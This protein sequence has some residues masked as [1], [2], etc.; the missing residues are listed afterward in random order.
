MATTRSPEDVAQQF[1]I[2][3]CGYTGERVAKQL[4]ALGP[5]VAITRRGRVFEFPSLIWDLDAT[6]PAGFSLSGIPAP[7]RVLYLVP[8]PA[9]GQDDPRISRFLEASPE[10]SAR[11][12]YIS[13]TSV[14]GDAGG[15]TVSEETPPAPITD[16][17]R[18]R[19]TAETTLR[20]W[21]ESKNVDWVILRVPGIYGPGR[22]PL[23]HLRRGEPVLSDAESGPGNRIHV[24]DLAV[25]CIAAMT[26][27]AA[28]NRIYNVGD[29]DHR[30]STAFLTLVA[31]LSGLPPPRQLPLEELK[32]HKS[33]AALSFLADARRA[34]TSR[35]RRELGFTPCYATLEAGVQASFNE[36]MRVNECRVV[37]S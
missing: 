18:R 35:L 4:V 23:D 5:T 19:L 8:P 10:A 34:D 31:S 2:V 20:A 28:R 3:G 30:S 14:Y 17:A 12:V 15:A 13:T 9:Q 21:C 26:R 36:S 33:E 22:L 37:V 6:V 7:Y 1:I 16:R 29:G 32:V 11:I 27:P 24:D 25:A